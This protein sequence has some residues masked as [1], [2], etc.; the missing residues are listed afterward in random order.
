MH[1]C[2]GPWLHLSQQGRANVWYQSLPL[3]SAGAQLQR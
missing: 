3:S 1:S 2:D